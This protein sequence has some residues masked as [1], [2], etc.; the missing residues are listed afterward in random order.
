MYF[1]YNDILKPW[2][3]QIIDHPID[4]DRL[5]Y[6]IA[7]VML[8]RYGRYP[9]ISLIQQSIFHNM[10]NLK[11]SRIQTLLNRC[12]FDLKFEMDNN[13]F[14]YTS[15]RRL[16]RPHRITPEEIKK[17]EDEIL[18]HV[19]M[20]NDKYN[21]N[22]NQTYIS[23]NNNYKKAALEKDIKFK[24]ELEFD[25]MFTD[26]IE[27]VWVKEENDPYF[28]DTIID[29]TEIDNETERY[30]KQ[31]DPY[32]DKQINFYDL[33][34]II[35]LNSKKNILSEK[36]ELTENDT[37]TKFNDS[38]N[39]LSQVYVPENNNNVVFSLSQADKDNIFTISQIPRMQ[40]IVPAKDKRS[41][42]NFLRVLTPNSYCRQK[43]CDK[44]TYNRLMMSSKKKD[45]YIYMK[46][47]DRNQFL[48]WLRQ[49][50]PGKTERQMDE[51][52]N[53]KKNK[54]KRKR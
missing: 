8:N 25:N 54:R 7:D 29:L 43:N 20:N 42:K 14:L 9:N 44:E 6:V 48:Q 4:H 50:Y 32:Y 22:N 3:S 26:C 27:D 49:T 21:K 16:N 53:L 17:D 52:F 46:R 31:K 34:N 37:S 41:I 38:R 19:I 2:V 1:E 36:E 5:V 40:K 10:Y 18:S 15:S 33:D 35:S 24:K 12:I 45:D 13:P 28:L 47:Q 30:M 11:K 23:N 39:I 51:Y